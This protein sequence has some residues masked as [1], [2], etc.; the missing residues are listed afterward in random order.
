MKSGK[1]SPHAFASCRKLADSFLSS[2][3]PVFSHFSEDIREI[4]NEFAERFQ[5]FGKLE[6]QDLHETIDC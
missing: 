2:E 5:D 1:G 4:I 3:P 6:C